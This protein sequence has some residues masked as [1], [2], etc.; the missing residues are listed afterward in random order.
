MQSFIYLALVLSLYLVRLASGILAYICMPVKLVLT[1][2]MWDIRQFIQNVHGLFN[3]LLDAL[4]LCS[5]L[6][7]YFYWFQQAE[8]YLR[9]FI[10]ATN[11]NAYMLHD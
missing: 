2:Y 10:A 7:I 1:L 3:M 6:Y 8:K 9:R 5:L 11:S 4:W